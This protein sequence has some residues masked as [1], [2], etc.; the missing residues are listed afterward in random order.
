SVVATAVAVGKKQGKTVIVVNDGV[1][2][3][4]TRVLLPYLNEASWLLTEGYSIET[5]DKALVDWGWPVGPIALIDEVGI[6]GG[7]HGGKVMREA[8]GDRVDSPDVIPRLVADDRKGR[9]NER[10]FYLY[11]EAAKRLGKGKHVDT[12]VY[13]VLGIGEPKGKP[14]KSA[15]E[16]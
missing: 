13:G 3:Y 9:K 15:I 4:T 14:S 1:G 6:D 11:G 7:V 12:S 16:D 2:F 10:G 8:F 5:I